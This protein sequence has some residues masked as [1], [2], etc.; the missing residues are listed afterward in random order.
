MPSTGCVPCLFLRKARDFSFSG[1][2]SPSI[3]A[4][5]RVPSLVSLMFLAFLAAGCSRTP[6]T[7]HERPPNPAAIVSY[8]DMTGRRVD[9]PRHPE[10]IISLAPSVTE[11]LYMVGAWDRVIGVTTQCDWPEAVR[12]KPKM[13]DLLNVNYEKILAARPDL[14]IASTAGNDRTAILKLADLNL[15]LFV[16]APRSVAGIFT[17]AEMIGRITDCAPQAEH[18]V[19]EIRDRLEQVK[20][21]LDGLPPVRAFFITWFD[22]LLAPGRNTFETDIL[23]QLDVISITAGINQF[24]PHCSV[25]QVLAEDPDVII[26]VE[27]TGNPLP[28]LRRI[29]GWQHLRAVREGRI[30]VLSEVFQHPSPRFVDAVEDLARKL[31]PERFR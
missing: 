10:R 30:Y 16:T 27:H 31:H 14:I 22:P 11:V 7:L 20:R 4:F 6:G 18:L 21:H 19:S 26:T 9:L 29:S 1:F 15:P 24:Y 28:D 17:T 8:T 12:L 2:R 23:R 3:G 5:C 25:E 13:G